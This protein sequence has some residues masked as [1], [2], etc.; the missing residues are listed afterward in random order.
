MTN[1]WHWYLDICKPPPLPLKLLHLAHLLL[2]FS[3]VTLYSSS[4]HWKWADRTVISMSRT[5]FSPQYTNIRLLALKQ[6]DYNT[7]ENSFWGSI[8]TNEL[9]MKSKTIDYLM[10]GITIRLNCDSVMITT[11]VLVNR[12]TQI[13]LTIV[14]H[15]LNK[16]LFKWV[17][18]VNGT[19]V[20]H[21]HQVVAISSLF[22]Q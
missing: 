19:A 1:N 17:L 18:S 8:W 12:E 11:N 20:S 21:P 9:W 2:L 14:W 16:M 7:Y 10:N 13:K 15:W 22:L 3:C 5:F 6:F 4:A